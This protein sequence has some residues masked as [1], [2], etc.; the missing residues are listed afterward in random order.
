[1]GRNLG[2]VSGQ[3]QVLRGS[4]VLPSEGEA[5][6]RGEVFAVLGERHVNLEQQRR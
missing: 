6:D 5:R 3:K 1:M 4:G 2:V